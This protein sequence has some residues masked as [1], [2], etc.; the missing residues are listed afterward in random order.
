MGEYSEALWIDHDGDPY[1]AAYV[2]GWEEGGFSKYIQERTSWINFSNVE[3]PVMGSTSDVGSS[4][5]SD[6]AEDAEGLLWMATWR[7]ILRFDPTVGGSSLQ[8]WG[9][10]NSLHPGG[11]T[12]DIDIAPDG[13][14]WAAVQSVTWGGG[15]LVNFNP[16]TNDMAILG[17]RF[18]SKQLAQ[19][20]RLLRTGIRAV[21]TGRWL[22]G[23]GRW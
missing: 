19:P 3:Y 18:N 21:Q 15:G 11:R 5:I 1:I 17:I 14:I 6:I 10:D 4:R 7:G 20:D 12:M 16:A 13:S 23:L 8:F 2:P 22:R 9:A